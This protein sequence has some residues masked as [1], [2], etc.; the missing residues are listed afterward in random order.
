MDAERQTRLLEIVRNSL[1]EKV[2]RFGDDTALTNATV[3]ELA[4]D[5]LEKLQLVLDLEMELSVMANE[6]D[7]AACRTVGDLLAVVTRAEPSPRKRG[8]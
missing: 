1:G 6:T 7:V 5:S 3:S 2:A 8:S 4:L